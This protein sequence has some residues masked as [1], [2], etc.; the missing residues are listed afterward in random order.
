MPHR[1]VPVMASRTRTAPCFVCK[2]RGVLEVD[3]AGL[4]AGETHMA[5]CP[6]CDGTGKIDAQLLIDAL[7]AAGYGVL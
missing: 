2:T 5:A 1:V 7:T 4:Y 6:S 3:T